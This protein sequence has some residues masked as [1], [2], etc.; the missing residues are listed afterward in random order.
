M[1]PLVWFLILSLDLLIVDFTNFDAW[2]DTWVALSTVEPEIVTILR[3]EWWFIKKKRFDVRRCLLHR[4]S[5]FSPLLGEEDY[6]T[7][8]KNICVGGY[9]RS[10]NRSF[11]I[12][13]PSDLKMVTFTVKF[14]CSLPTPPHYDPDFKFQTRGCHEVLKHG[15]QV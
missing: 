15:W 7:S 12:N 3:S 1:I 10:S 5:S 6:L 2:S 13:R 8:P 11:V 14:C 4:H 9:S